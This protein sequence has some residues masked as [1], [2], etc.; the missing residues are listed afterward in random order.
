M[1]KSNLNEDLAGMPPQLPNDL[2]QMFDKDIIPVTYLSRVRTFFLSYTGI[3]LAV[4]CS[5]L[6]NLCGIFPALAVSGNEEIF[7]GLIIIGCGIAASFSLYALNKFSLISTTALIG[8]SFLNPAL[9]PAV[10]FLLALLGMRGQRWRLLPVAIM[11]FI[12]LICGLFFV[13]QF[14]FFDLTPG[15]MFAILTAT[16]L[17]FTLGSLG[18][19]WLDIAARIDHQL[20]ATRIRLIRYEQLEAQTNQQNSRMCIARTLHDEVSSKIAVISLHA[21][22]LEHEVKN[23]SGGP[24]QNVLAAIESIRESSRAA[25]NSLAKMLEQLSKPVPNNSS[26]PQ[27]AIREILDLANKNAAVLGFTI[28][29]ERPEEISEEDED[30]FA[31]FLHEAFTNAFKYSPKGTV[32]VAK[33]IVDDFIITARVKN[34]VSDSHKQDHKRIKMGLQNLREYAHLQGGYFQVHQT[35]DPRNVK[36]FIIEMTLPR[37]EKFLVHVNN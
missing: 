3:T 6:I 12:A 23:K 26:F 16:V 28:E 7:P 4:T 11:G 8:F 15:S 17:A 20:V 32:I 31:Y 14:H 21:E 29:Y 9:A 2:I 18:G 24:Q 19:I 13:H 34:Q 27:F 37:D 33:Y 5:V 35:E 1:Q 10:A 36:E 25:M 30:N 22:V